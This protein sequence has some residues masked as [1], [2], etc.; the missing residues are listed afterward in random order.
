MSNEII[1]SDNVSE[2]NISLDKAYDQIEN[3]VYE[4]LE[5]A[6]LLIKGDA[7]VRAPSDLGQLRAS[8][9]FRIFKSSASKV[10]TGIV[11]ANTEYAAYV[12][13]GTG[14]Y[15]VEGNGRKTPWTYKDRKGKFVITRGQRPKPYLKE[16]SEQNVAAI[17]RI[18][19][20]E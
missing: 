9:N 7:I 4:R 20:G 5:R 17:G 11:F 10:I 12:H 8:I 15:A 3:I 6:C 2:F 16:A 1:V 13:Q 19:R 18:L 14:I